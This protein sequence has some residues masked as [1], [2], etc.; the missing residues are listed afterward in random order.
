LPASEILSK[1]GNIEDLQLDNLI[2]PPNDDGE[3]SILK[4][5]PYYDISSLPSHLAQ[6]GGQLNI[7]SLNAQSLN[8]KFDEILALL[9]IALTQN[10]QFHVICIQETWLDETADTSLLQIDG[11]KMYSQ[12][13]RRE[14]SN[15]GG[16][17]TYVH[18]NLDTYRLDVS[19]RSTLWEKN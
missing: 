11:Y 7:L 6:P 4:P 1:F 12:S 18:E 14:C 13:K 2:D 10:I 3:F 8:A 16:L 19:N 17:I 15:H 5:S 9:E